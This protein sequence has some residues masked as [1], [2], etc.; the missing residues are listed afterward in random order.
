MRFNFKFKDETP[1]AK[2]LAGLGFI[3]MN[4]VII[5]GY[6]VGHSNSRFN[7]IMQEV[8]PYDSMWI[9]IQILLVAISLPYMIDIRHLLRRKPRIEN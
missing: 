5:L 9:L 4:A 7:E 2:G 8:L 1:R 3:Y 6:W